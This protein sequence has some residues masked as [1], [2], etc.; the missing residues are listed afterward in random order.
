VR[1]SDGRLFTVPAVP[2]N[3]Q[4]LAHFDEPTANVPLVEDARYT[5]KIKWYIKPVALGGDPSVGGNLTWV[6]HQQHGELVV[7]WN[8]WIRD[9]EKSPHGA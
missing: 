9:I 3:D 5:G 6:N 1:S 8:R 2:L 7:W 4:R